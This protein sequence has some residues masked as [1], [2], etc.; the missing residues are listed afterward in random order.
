[1]AQ[2]QEAGMRA[3]LGEFKTAIALYEQI[4]RS[5]K[6]AMFRDYAVIRASVLLSETEPLDKMKARLDP[7]ANADGPWKMAAKELL[8]YAYWRAGKT[9][10]ALKVY[11]EILKAEDVPNGTKRRS[12]EMKAL[13]KAGLK[14]S[15]VKPPPRVALPDIPTPDIG[16]LLLQPAT[17]TPEQPGSLLGPAPTVPAPPTP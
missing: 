16:P 15:D 4:A 9:A 1:L 12:V 8:A 11:E 5:N 6:D 10:D 17:P 13:L 3:E 7:V 14:V 2:F